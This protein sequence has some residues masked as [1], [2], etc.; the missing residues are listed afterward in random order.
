MKLRKGP[1]TFLIEAGPEYE[2]RPGRFTIERR[3][4][5]DTEVV[6]R[7]RVDMKAEG[8]WAARSN[9]PCPTDAD[10]AVELA[11]AGALARAQAITVRSVAGEK[12][13]RIVGYQLGEIPQAV[14]AGDMAGEEPQYVPI[15][16][17][18]VPF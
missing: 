16:D 12:Y 6:L 8:W 7:R 17:D 10:E 15:S 1:Y 13:D 3:A 5:D 2:T 11:E 4:E 14:T 9:D 18:E